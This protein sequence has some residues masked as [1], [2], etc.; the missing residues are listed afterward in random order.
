MEDIVQAYNS[1]IGQLPTS[2]IPLVKIAMV[3]IVSA[4]I[5][6]VADGFIARIF[7]MGKN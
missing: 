2:I 6:K 7:Y 3:L 1:L 5:I 4:F